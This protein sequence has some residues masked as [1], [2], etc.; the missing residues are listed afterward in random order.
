MK[1]LISFIAVLALAAIA[2][3]GV[4]MGNMQYLF[5]V[6]IPYLAVATFVVGMIVRVLKWASS[7]DPFRI[8]TTSGQQKSLPWIKHSNIESPSTVLGRHRADGAG[9]PLLPVALPEPEDPGG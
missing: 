4:A 7:P 1:A 9:S 3:A 8:P 5:G 6:V 2:Y